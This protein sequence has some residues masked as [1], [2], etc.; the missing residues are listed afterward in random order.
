MTKKND[1]AYDELAYPS[2]VHSQTHPDRLATVATLLGLKPQT[3]EN[4]RVLE[5][6]CGDGT[7]SIAFAG[8][9]PESEFV[10]ID[11]SENQIGYG[12]SIKESI[13][14]K[15]L[16]LI[17]ADILDLSRDELGEFDYIIA[18][19]VYSWTPEIVR[20]KVLALCREMLSEQGIAFVSYNTLPG[21]HL[22]QMARDI[23]VYHTRS[24]KDARQKVDEAIGFLDFLTNTG[25]KPEIYQNT[26]AHELSDIT[27]SHRNVIF[28]DI[29]EQTNTPVYFYQFITH[30]EKHD[31]RFLSEI[32]YFTKKDTSYNSTIREFLQAFGDDVTRREQYIDFFIN[33]RFR[34]TLLCRKEIEVS[35]EPKV[36]FLQNLRIGA[37]VRAKSEQCNFEPKMS[38]IF[39][40]KQ[41]T[42]FEIDHSLTKA[43]LVHLGEIYP[44][45]INFAELA[46]KACKKTGIEFSE[47]DERILGEVLMQ[48]YTVGLV[49]F[50]VHEPVYADQPGEKPLVGKFIK[51]QIENGFAAITNLRFENI[52]IENEFAR[53]LLVLFDGTRTREDVLQKL[54]TETEFENE[55]EKHEFVRNLPDLLKEHIQKLAYFGIF[56]K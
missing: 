29:L 8:S 37:D 26:L 43:A 56:M 9:L 1:F 47:N 55:A 11:L 23:A 38:E 4:C 42:Q 33:R 46:E 19:G 53:K 28:H 36:E 45:S 3:A 54:K 22:R 48:I 39:I 41:D 24:I 52:R 2:F 21:Y 18:H 6:G 51:W 14:L 25:G 49:N 32:E 15:N 40:G 30:A 10:G 50:C 20:D 5:L 7:N 17:Q 35:T 27:T 13:G 44:H 34:Q 31:L 12:N 16:K